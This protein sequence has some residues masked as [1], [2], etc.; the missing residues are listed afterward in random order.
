[1]ETS[2]AC[3]SIVEETAVVRKRNCLPLE[4]L[5]PLVLPKSDPPIS[6]SW[7]AIFGNDH[8]VELEI[9]FGKGAFLV[10]AAAAHPETNYVGM[11]IDWGL[12]LYVA[13]RLVKRGLGNVR[14]VQG[15]A[16]VIV[17]RSVPSDSLHAIHVY[18]PDPWWKRRHRKRRLLTTEFVS[19]CQH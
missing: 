14:L 3:H 4:Q 5:Q 1:R 11:E 2:S 17:A 16:H 19:A 9:G 15:D 12:L 13:N 8:P 7:H 6:F 18:F 10:A